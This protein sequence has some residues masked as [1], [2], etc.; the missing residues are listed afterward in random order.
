MSPRRTIRHNS[1]LIA[2]VPDLHSALE[3]WCATVP[4][5]VTRVEQRGPLLAVV[6]RR[7]RHIRP[8]IILIAGPGALETCEP[9]VPA[10]RPDITDPWG[11]RIPPQL[12]RS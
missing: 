1:T 12:L 9:E 8:T 3:W 7:R 5:R 10:G 2:R 6:L 11:N 4:A